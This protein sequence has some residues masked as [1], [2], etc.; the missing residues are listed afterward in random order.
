MVTN[1][2]QTALP[3]LEFWKIFKLKKKDRKTEVRGEVV[4]VLNISC[5]RQRR[6][7]IPKQKPGEVC[8][9]CRAT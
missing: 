1:T 8:T 5:T 4:P 7:I 3:E 6:F 2:K 9:K